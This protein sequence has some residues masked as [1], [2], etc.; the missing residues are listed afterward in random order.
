[1]FRVKEVRQCK[2]KVCKLRNLQGSWLI[3]QGV[4]WKGSELVRP[5]KLL[6]MSMKG[7]ILNLCSNT[8]S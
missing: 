4:K 7:G 6:I 8:E 1:M 5:T 3:T 2:T